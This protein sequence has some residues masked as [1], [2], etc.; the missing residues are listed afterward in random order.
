L[1][2]F[3]VQTHLCGHAMEMLRGMALFY[4]LPPALFLRV[5]IESV[6]DDASEDGDIQAQLADGARHCRQTGHV[7]DC[8]MELEGDFIEGDFTEGDYDEHFEG[9]EHEEG[10]DDSG[11]ETYTGNEKTADREMRQSWAV[12]GDSAAEW[13]ERDDNHE[14]RRM[15]REAAQKRQEA[16]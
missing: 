14:Y 12:Y 1:K 15:A 5:I 11:P 6:L 8:W 2:A 7:P 10:P 4:N 9:S 3:P 16:A 13:G